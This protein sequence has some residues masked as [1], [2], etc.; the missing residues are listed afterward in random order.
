MKWFF[1][2]YKKHKQMVILLAAIIG[3]P[4]ALVGVNVLDVADKA[5]DEARATL[6]KSPVKVPEL[7]PE[8]EP[9]QSQPASEPG[10]E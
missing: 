8:L 10:Q 1:E 6:G 7:E 4:A 5:H 9:E 2:R 3:T